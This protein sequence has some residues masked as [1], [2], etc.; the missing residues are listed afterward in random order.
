MTQTI[1][2]SSGR[3]ESQLHHLGLLCFLLGEGEQ[4]GPLKCKSYNFT[5]KWVCEGMTKAVLPGWQFVSCS[6]LT[7]DFTIL[8]ALK[9]PTKAGKRIGFN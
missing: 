3:S 9:T 6:L 4:S 5:D 2:S 8:I 1:S 7:P